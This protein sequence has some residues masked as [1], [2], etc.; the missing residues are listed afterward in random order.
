[1]FVNCIDR[2]R[3]LT[4]DEPTPTESVIHQVNF[5]L[6]FLGHSF[7]TTN[8][9]WLTPHLHRRHKR[10]KGQEGK[11]LRMTDPERVEIDPRYLEFFTAVRH[12][13]DGESGD[14]YR[15]PPS[16][17]YIRGHYWSCPVGPRSEGRREYRPRRGCW[18]GRRV[19]GQDPGPTMFKQ[20]S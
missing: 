3:R 4:A 8:L 17:H 14:G 6:G 20:A 11:I 2:G 1:M 10:I 18:R 13:F 16:G 15:R 19:E 7:G 5:N 12:R 9:G